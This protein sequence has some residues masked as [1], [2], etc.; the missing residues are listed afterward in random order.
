LRAGRLRIPQY[1]A[2]TTRVYRLAVES[3]YAGNF[4]AGK[5]TQRACTALEFNRE[6]TEGYMFDATGIIACDSP[7]R[8]K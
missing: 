8:K 1:T 4:T 7:K 2:L 3:Y 5:R 6:F